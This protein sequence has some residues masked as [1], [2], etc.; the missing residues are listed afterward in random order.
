MLIPPR[1]VRAEPFPHAVVDNAIPVAEAESLGAFI[2]ETI[3][4]KTPAVM[5]GRRRAVAGSRLY[6]SLRRNHPALNGV[7]EE[8]TSRSF[9]EH[10]LDAL[11]PALDPLT[12]CRFHPSEPWRL[13]AR[14]A[15]PHPDRLSVW[16]L[17]ASL[18]P[19]PQSLSMYVDLS[20]AGDGYMREVHA[21][22]P[23]RL[24][25]GILYL[26]DH[27]SNGGVGGELTL[28]ARPASAPADPRRQPRRPVDAPQ[29][30]KIPPKPGRLVV[31]LST[32]D[33]YHAVR[34]M[35]RTMSPRCFLYFGVTA[36]CKDVWLRHPDVERNGGAA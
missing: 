32:N 27:R 12:L 26:T 17:A 3:G 10:L 23:N 1:A 21:D 16:W 5:G 25:A 18:R 31:F 24:A 34:R 28:H 30:A 8:L 36:R 29:V 33:A 9:V 14:R 11:W 35:E 15:P 22:L 20:S 7:L 4:E 19:S 6:R 2:G 13:Q